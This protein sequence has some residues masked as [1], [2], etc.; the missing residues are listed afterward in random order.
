M[1]TLCNYSRTKT[2]NGIQEFLVNF[3][4]KRSEAQSPLAAVVQSLEA[5]TSII[6]LNEPHHVVALIKQAQEHKPEVVASPV[7]CACYVETFLQLFRVTRMV[8]TAAVKMSCAWM[9][10]NFR[11]LLIH[12]D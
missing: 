9:Q 8:S 11:S 1:P 12:A 4:R 2:H 6:A 3:T 7:V 10:R 5:A